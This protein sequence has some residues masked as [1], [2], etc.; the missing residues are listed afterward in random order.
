MNKYKLNFLD[1]SLEKVYQKY[2]KPYMITKFY[3]YFKLQLFFMFVMCT[4]GLIKENF[5]L[6]RILALIG[7][8]IFVVM[9]FITK[10]YLN[11][12]IF[13]TIIII[14]CSGIGIIF[15]EL[16]E[17]TDDKGNVDISAIMLG[18]AFQFYL[19]IIL[20][21]R[22]SWIY[23]GALYFVNV[24]YLLGR[25]AF[26]QSKFKEEIMIGTTMLVINFIIISYR[27]EKTYRLYF[28]KLQESNDNL[29]KFKEIMQGILPNPIFILNYDE[30]YLEFCNNSADKLLRKTNFSLN[31]EYLGE[32]KMFLSQRNLEESNKISLKKLENV[33]DSFTVLKEGLH[34]FHEKKPLMS[35]LMKKFVF[36]KKQGDD[37]L[38]NTVIYNEKFQTIH[39]TNGQEDSD[40]ITLLEE[41]NNQILFS[42]IKYYEVKLCNINWENK[43][44]LLMIFTDQT[45]AKRL[46]ELMNLDRYKNQM[47]A[48]VSHD[49]RTPLNGVIGMMS[50]VLP[51]LHDK[52]SKKNLTIGIRSA[53]LLNYLINDILDFSQITYKKLRL[54]IERINIVDLVSEIFSLMKLQA[55]KK[56]LSFKREIY[57]NDLEVVYS[58]SARIKQILL[59]L[60]GNAIKFTKEGSIIL[61]VESIDNED[62]KT[63]LFYVIDTGIK[64]EDK[65]KLFGLFGAILMD[66]NMPILDG[67]KARTNQ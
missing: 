57:L 45:K 6:Q 29:Q 41:Q 34:S 55:K 46:I 7:F 5:S 32:K 44:C 48:T 35:E 9:F 10:R 37:F 42:K 23:S 4:L 26:W 16:M 58:D 50:S 28:K 1:P 43:S 67:F 61:K 60:L 33:M 56:N 27:H 19:N 54:N 22:V 31:K 40:Q 64:P 59:N 18:L 51:I 13:E 24:A 3:D 21:T 8:C 38:E 47:L 39:I 65:D 30:N 15:V 17:I 53:Y 63:L 20:L 12:I 66:C 52:E 36:A 62:S 49:L 11:K 25:L 14:F 2:N